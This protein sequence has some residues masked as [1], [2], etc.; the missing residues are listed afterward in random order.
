VGSSGGGI[1]LPAIVFAPARPDVRP[2]HADDVIFE[3]H[4]TGDGGRVLPVFTT[5]G[6][7]VFALGS[8]QPW[9]AL[10]LANIQRIMGAAGVDRIALDPTGEPGAWQWQDSD[11]EALERRL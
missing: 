9:V 11:L 2:G 3:V 5:I 6:Q 7:L 8:R 10:P 4:Q 1:G